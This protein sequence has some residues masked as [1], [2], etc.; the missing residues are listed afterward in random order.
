MRKR[1]EPLIQKSAAEYLQKIRDMEMDGFKIVLY[2]AGK[3]GKSLARYITKKGINIFSYCVS[4]TQNNVNAIEGIPVRLFSDL[5]T[6]KILFLVAVKPPSNKEIVSLLEAKNV[7]SFI[8][9]PI[10]IEQILAFDKNTTPLTLEITPKIGCIVNCKYCP[11]ELLI[12]NYKKKSNL[13]EMTF[14][15]FQSCID[16]LP[17][18]TILE[19]TG[20]VEPFTAHDTIE[21]IQYANKQHFSMRLNTTLVG[22]TLASFKQIEAI[23][24]LHTCIHLPDRSGFAHIP[25]TESYLELLKYT[26]S[27]R[28]DGHM[29]WEMASCQDEP[30]PEVERY[31][32][33]NLPCSW[34]LF[35][36]AGNLSSDGVASQSFPKGVPIYCSRDIDL[37]HNVLLPN[38][39]IQ[40]CCMDYGCVHTLGNLLAQSYEDILDGKQMSDIK[41]DLLGGGGHVLCYKCTKARPIPVSV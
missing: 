5:P 33:P 17:S 15:T 19:F 4:D 36:R 8:D 20:F 24:F 34:N 13:H 29:F 23:P 25:I 11:Q 22:L 18:G 41:K 21:M 27:K 14:E 39:D 6:E 37:N 38:G 32:P 12:R 28:A 2:G 10:F 35:D 16:K 31:L 40:L 1:L 7:S 30:A 3:Y 26:M 9:I